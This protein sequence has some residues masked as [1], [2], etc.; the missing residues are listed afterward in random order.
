M[1]G[2]TATIDRRALRAEV[3]TA[4]GQSPV[5]LLLGARQCGK[6]TLARQLVAPDAANYFDLENPVHLRRLQEPLT[7]L[8]PLTGTV[9]VDEVHRQ[10]ELFQVLRVLAD[11]SPAPARFLLLGSAS[12][13]L[14]QQASE[15]LAGRVTIVSMGGFSLGELGGDASAKLWLR[16]GYPRAFLAAD[17]DAAE[18]WRRDYVRMVLERDVPQFGLGI[19]ATALHRFWSM[20]AHCHGGI[21]HNSDPARSLGV[22][23][24]TIR[25]YLDLMTDMLLLRQLQPW[26]ENLAK[27][28]VKA[29]KVYFRDSGLL[30]HFLGVTTNE[31]LL[32]HVRCGASWEGFVVEEVLRCVRP[33]AQ[34]FWAT[35][36]GAELD[37]LLFVKGKRLGVEVKRAD[38]PGMT[39]SLEVARHDLKLDGAI[40]V[41]PGDQRYAIAPGVEAVPVTE[42]AGDGP[43]ALFPKL[44][45]TPRSRRRAS[46]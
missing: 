23:E 37:L 8:A 18:A 14:L 21:W 38:A 29:P 10:P 24:S 16:G 5:V 15:S 6:T 4:L 43:H 17:E 40:V 27:R 30:H 45:A 22:A 12:L 26:H 39:K 42:L 34:Y 41:Y 28:Q 11:R 20:V 33:D 44:F 1:M 2:H 36:S 13:A 19:A 35:H 3:D 32:G 25:R 7:A 46:R 31:E 9:I